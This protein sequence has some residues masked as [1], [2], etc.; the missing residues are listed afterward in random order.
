MKT[1]RAQA[2]EAALP[3]FNIHPEM[4]SYV[5]YCLFK[6]GLRY[7]SLMDSRLERHGLVAPQCGILSLLDRVGPMTQVELGGYILIDKATMVR[8]LDG[9][10]EK[11]LLV[12]VTDPKDR[13]AKKLELTPVGRKFLTTVRAVIVEVDDS[14]LGRLSKKERESLKDLV[15]KIVMQEN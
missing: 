11:K 1:K 15:A 6:M 13:R 2:K 5:G 12:R 7:R 9:L 3:K 8:M 4:R 14:I 10:E